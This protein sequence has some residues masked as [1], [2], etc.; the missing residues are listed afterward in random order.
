M[1]E[2]GLT[3]QIRELTHTDFEE[4]RHCWTSYLDFYKT[5]LED[6]MILL[7]WER[8]M[9]KAPQEFQAFAAFHQKKQMLGLVHFLYH[10]HGWKMNQVCYLQDLFVHQQFRNQGIARQLIEAVYQQSKQNNVCQVYWLTQDFN[11]TARMLYDKI[12]QQ[13]SFIKYQHDINLTFD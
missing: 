13:T 9:S 4:W 3:I 10:R 2:I 7:A 8:L 6:E 12:S 5:K 11:M 1:S